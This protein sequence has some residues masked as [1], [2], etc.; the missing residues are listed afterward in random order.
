MFVY[1][2]G[3]ASLATAEGVR[4]MGSIVSLWAKEHASTDALV[5]V[6]SAMAKNTNL[7]EQILAAQ[8]NGDVAQTQT[9][10]T[11]FVN[12]HISLIRELF[13]ADEASALENAIQ[14]ECEDLQIA[15]RTF[16]QEDYSYHYDR[17]IPYGE[18]LSSR[19][20]GAYLSYHQ[21]VCRV[22]DARRVLRSNAMHR[23]AV[24]DMQLSRPLVRSQFANRPNHIYVTQGF[25]ASCAT[26]ETTT[27]GREGSDYSA[28]LIGAFLDAES[29]TIWKDVQGVY[30]ADPKLFPSARFLPHVDYREAI[31]LSYNGAKVI[32]PKAIKPLQNQ[33][34]P[35]YVR[36][37]CTPTHA[38]TL[39]DSKQNLEDYG[40]P[41]HAKS[42]APLL[43]AV[44]ANQRLISFT[45]HDLSLA[46]QE[47]LGEV[48]VTLQSHGVHIGLVQTS[49]V[50]ISVCV[51]EDHVR[52]ERALAALHTLFS[53]AYNCDLVLLTLRNYTDSIRHTIEKEEGV[54]LSQSTRATVQY[55]L[56][57]STWTSVVYPQL[58][59]YVART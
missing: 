29:V 34:I 45:P 56:T 31:E 41:S 19:I 2:F 36:P 28:A 20:V 22:V 27:L 17:V 15:L 58:E 23:D 53:I 3:G 13:P 55:L 46:L 51:T 21:Y 1:K 38:G 8:R 48:C 16:S 5:V 42:N 54:L 11:T 6:V 37:Y 18:L 43:I 47:G 26:G 25:I 39:I 12:F 10:L 33:D 14:L 35:L 59:Q 24:V 52:V 44:K 32:H 57:E 4:Q 30:S 40:L 50:S 7:L 9:L 49:A